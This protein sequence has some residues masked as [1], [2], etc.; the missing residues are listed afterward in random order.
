[1]ESEAAWVDFALSCMACSCLEG[2]RPRYRSRELLCGFAWKSA[3]LTFIYF[4]A[5]K[6]RLGTHRAQKEPA[7]IPPTY[8]CTGFFPNYRED[9]CQLTLP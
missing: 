7:S 3:F 8:L 9:G 5:S 1:M 2:H 6:A 4:P